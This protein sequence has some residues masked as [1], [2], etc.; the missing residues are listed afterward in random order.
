[1]VEIKNTSSGEKVASLLIKW[2]PRAAAVAI[3]G[4]Y[5]L[6]LAYEFGWMVLID[7]VAIYIIK[8]FFGTVGVGAIMP[9]AQWYSAW[10]ARFVIGIGT[11]FLYDGCEK[12]AFKCWEKISEARP[13]LSW[14]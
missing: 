1:M 13:Y 11:G 4:Y 6:G 5:G 2:T 7:K 9:T 10:A 3:G 8:N 14:G 12:I